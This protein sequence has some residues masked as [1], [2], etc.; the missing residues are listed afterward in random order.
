MGREIYKL[1]KDDF[2]RFVENLIEN[3]ETIGVKEKR[4]NFVFSELESSREL[5]L[6]YDITILPPKV[7]LLPPYEKLMKFDVKEQRARIS[8]GETK[9]IIIGVHPYDIVAIKQMDEVYLKESPDELYKSR[10]ENTIIIGSDIIN[11]SEYS[12]ASSLGTHRVED[13]FDLLL[14]ELDDGIII[15]VGSEKGK[16]LLFK[17]AQG[18]EEASEKH[19]E[20]VERHREKLPEKYKLKIEIEKDQIPFLLMDVYEHPFW[21]EESEKCLQ[22]GSCTIVCPTCYCYDV[23]DE[24]SITLESGE[25]IR[26]WDSC[27]LPD[28]TKIASGEIFRKSKLD[29]Y[30]H[31]FYRKGLY[32][33]LRYNFI[34][35]VGCGRCIKACIPKIANPAEAINTLLERRSESKGKL[36]YR[37]PEGVESRASFVPEFA[38]IRRIETLTESEKLFEIEMVGRDKFNFQPGQFVEVSIFGVGEAPISISSPPTG[39]NRFELV[40]RKVG[41]LTGK[42]HSMKEGDKIG[43]RGP[44]GKGFNID[45]MEGKDLLFVAGGIG[46]VPLRSL[47]K[48]V[49]SKNNRSR[50][51]K[52]FILYGSRTPKDMLFMDEIK[53]WEKIRDV[54]IKLSVDTCPEGM[55][56]DGC[57][58]VVTTLFPKIEIK[59]PKNTVAVVVGPPVMY[60][61]VIKC[62]KD[63]GIRDEDIFV[64]LERRMK[65]GIGKCGHCQINGVYVCKEGPVFRYSEIKDLPEA[66]S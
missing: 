66:F 32:I 1:D 37:L 59:D 57:V 16:E 7:F 24:V 58:G 36:V 34:A 14:T 10:R 20:K 6:D 38:M 44:L 46:I 50:F 42:L 35:C 52:V 49:L 30:R 48:Y 47:I 41:N 40:V 17:Y 51:G 29:R 23:R 53:E 64:S 5:R 9:R 13:G 62:L 21:E 25:R 19:I 11:V 2:Y 43:I 33:P 65:C 12:F 8:K 56:W 61:F 22:C 55:R 54:E 15:E 18:I 31:R 26:T 28:F 27:L 3:F 63:I 39:S 4:G 45:E 60:K